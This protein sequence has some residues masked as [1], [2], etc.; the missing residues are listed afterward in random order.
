MQVQP[1][2][3]PRPGDCPQHPCGVTVSHPWQSSPRLRMAHP[4]RFLCLT[5]QTLHSEAEDKGEGFD[6][7]PLSITSQASRITPL[8]ENSVQMHKHTFGIWESAA[9]RSHGQP[10]ESH[11]LPGESYVTGKKGM[12]DPG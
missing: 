4:L 1:A 5:G 7:L 12:K 3:L 8:E 6:F 2:L 9:Q 11:T 10:R